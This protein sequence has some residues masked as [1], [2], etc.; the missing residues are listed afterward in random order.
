MELLAEKCCKQQGLTVAF[1]CPLDL[2]TS[3]FLL[4]S[5]VYLLSRLNCTLGDIS[6]DSINLS[7]GWATPSTPSCPPQKVVSYPKQLLWRQLAQSSHPSICACQQLSGT[8]LF[9]K[10]SLF[11][12][13][14][15]FVSLLLLLGV[16]QVPAKSVSPL[17]ITLNFLVATGWLDTLL[18]CYNRC[19]VTVCNGEDP[20]SQKCQPNAYQCC[21]VLADGHWSCLCQ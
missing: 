4:W 9:V 18:L 10:S 13:K 12:M 15:L 14:Q 6:A 11:L 2:K 5:I 7:G 19:G 17:V 20:D 1:L 21:P 8:L 16:L 3:L